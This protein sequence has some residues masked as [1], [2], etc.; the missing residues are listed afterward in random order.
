MT[1]LGFEWANKPYYASDYFD[2]LHE[3]AI[4]LIKQGDAYVDLQTPEQ[5]R[6]TRGSFNEP[7]KPSPQR[8]ASVEENLQRFDDM[9]NGKYAE[10]EAVL[11]AKIDI[12]KRVI[13]GVSIPCM[14]LLI[15]YQMPLKGLLTQFVP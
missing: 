15:L 5:I 7:G 4:K 3:W 12:T 9:K 14:T 10:G 13:S 2:Q 6:E 8:D 11:R 1:W